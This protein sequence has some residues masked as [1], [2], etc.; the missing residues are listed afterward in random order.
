MREE[1]YDEE[2][3]ESAP[4]KL[5]LWWHDPDRR[6]LVTLPCGCMGCRSD[7]GWEKFG[8]SNRDPNNFMNYVA[9]QSCEDCWGEGVVQNK[10][11]EDSIKW[12]RASKPRL[13][14]LE[15]EHCKGQGGS[16]QYRSRKCNNCDGNGFLPKND[17]FILC[18]K[19]KGYKKT[20]SKHIKACKHCQS[21]GKV[22]IVC[23]V[24]K[25]KL[26]CPLCQ[27]YFIDEGDENGSSIAVGTCQ[28]CDGSG[29]FRSRITMSFEFEQWELTEWSIIASRGKSTI[30]PGVRS[31]S[32]T[33]KFFEMPKSSSSKNNITRRSIGEFDGILP[34]GESLLNF[35]QTYNIDNSIYFAV[36]HHND[37]FEYDAND[38]LGYE[39]PFEGGLAHLYLRILCKECDGAQTY[40][41]TC[42]ACSGSRYFEF[43]RY[44]EI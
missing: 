44:S 14:E 29:A 16:T 37:K 22:P 8:H 20:E 39:V 34:E 25:H 3:E 12:S 18:P 43:T 13:I 27:K 24:E 6:I 42:P 30:I 33:V 32:K 41:I 10:I 35:L 11:H 15:C 1:E 31:V 23:K 21:K 19:C 17:E 2:E 4:D 36:V 5:E 40:R 38:T 26:S 9:Q 7:A 28:K